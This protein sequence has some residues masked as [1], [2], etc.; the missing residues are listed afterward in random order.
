MFF[1]QQNQR[2]RG[3]NRFC[4]EAGGGEVV[5]LVYVHVS[6]CTSGKIKLKKKFP[7]E[8]EKRALTQ[9]I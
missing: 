2:T 6:T 8:I 3:G 5:Q 7:W 1:L 4:S 9:M